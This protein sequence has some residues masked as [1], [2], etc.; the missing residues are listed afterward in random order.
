MKRF[1]KVLDAIIDTEWLI[2]SRLNSD[3]TRL[4][5]RQSENTTLEFTG[6]ANE[7]EKAQV[8]LWEQIEKINHEK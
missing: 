1:V 8:S 3:H 5:I 7:M 6:T 2:S 4:I